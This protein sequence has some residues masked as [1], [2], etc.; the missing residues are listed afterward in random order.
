MTIQQIEA[1]LETARCNSFSQAALNLYSS[2]PTLSR[3]VKALED[4]L[5]VQLLIRSKNTVHLSSIGAT[6]KPELED[7]KNHFDTTSHN[8]RQTIKRYSESLLIGIQEGQQIEGPLAEVIHEYHKQY[9]H[10]EL[11]LRAFDIRRSNEAIMN[12]EIDCLLNLSS[13]ISENSVIATYE[14]A[15]DAM[16]LAVPKAHPHSAVKQLYYRE[17]PV[18]FP[19]LPLVL[20]DIEAF[21]PPPTDMLKNV[22][23]TILPETVR[24]LKEEDSQMNTLRLM[25][26]HELCIS[27][28]N[29]HS[30]T[31]ECQNIEMIP[32]I[33]ATQGNTVQTAI[34]NLAWHRDNHNPA[35]ENFL[36]L[37]KQRMPRKRL[38]SDLA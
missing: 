11:K 10:I 2:Q 1:F 4:E 13:T 14:L 31:S 30:V 9:P 8:V 20:I 5:G 25:V 17:I 24:Y 6:I 22:R 35:L 37:V 7:L 12:Q 18:L 15:E 33:S 23:D 29:R 36:A 28:F 27:V 16:C 3:Q 21:G 26:E 32:L 34:I 38:L 19:D